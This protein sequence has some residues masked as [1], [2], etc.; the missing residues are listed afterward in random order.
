MPSLLMLDITTSPTHGM[1]I[2]YTSVPDWSSSSHK[3][4]FHV[5]HP[6]SMYRT[7]IYT[8]KVRR[9]FPQPF[10]AVEKTR[11]HTANKCFQ[12]LASCTMTTNLSVIDTHQHDLLQVECALSA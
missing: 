3:Q 1:M 2:R 10:L 6:A 7:I 8:L 11:K 4:P 5:F 12:N 9:M